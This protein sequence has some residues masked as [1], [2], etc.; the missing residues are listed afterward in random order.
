M[1]RMEIRVFTEDD[2]A[3]VIRLWDSCDLLR[4][5]NDPNEDIDRK[6]QFQ[7]NLFFVGEI[8]SKIIASAM[9]GYD[10]HRGSAFYLAIDP[11]FQ[12]QG[13]GRNLMQHIELVLAE[14]GCPKLNILVR[15]DNS[16]VLDFYQRQGYPI[17]QVVSVGK[18]LIPDK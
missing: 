3:T 4:S 6:I 7:P 2:R 15:S 8:N 5:W 16:S 17:D 10:G 13:L 12:G 9:A 18:R 11:D 1:N 14:L